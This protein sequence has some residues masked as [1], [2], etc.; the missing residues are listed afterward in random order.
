MSKFE[1]YM[2]NTIKRWSDMEQRE[3]NEDI[4]FMEKNVLAELMSAL[5]A[6][7]TYITNIQ[8]EDEDQ[9]E[10]LIRNWMKVMI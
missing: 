6:F 1:V 10:I 4:K 5:Y 8:L 2:I 9:D 3:K 7:N